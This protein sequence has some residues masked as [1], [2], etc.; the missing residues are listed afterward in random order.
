MLLIPGHVRRKLTRT[1]QWDERRRCESAVHRPGQAASMNFV[2]TSTRY[3]VF[4]VRFEPIRFGRRSQPFDH[5]DW[6]FEPQNSM[7]LVPSRIE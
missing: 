6:I 4:R 5:L 7:A 3:N 2:C 1:A